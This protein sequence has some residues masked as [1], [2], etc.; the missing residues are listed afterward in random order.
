MTDL[1]YRGPPPEL[2]VPDRIPD[3]FVDIFIDGR[4]DFSSGRPFNVNTPHMGHSDTISVSVGQ[5]ILVFNSGVHFS[6]EW[7][8]YDTDQGG[9]IQSELVEYL[10]N[11][12][13]GRRSSPDDVRIPRVTATYGGVEQ[14]RNPGENLQIDSSRPPTVAAALLGLG[15]SCS[16]LDTESRGQQ[17]LFLWPLPPPG[18]INLTFLW[19]ALGFTGTVL[20]DGQDLRSALSPNEDP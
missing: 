10:S 17:E 5:P 9:N 4:R 16:K 3:P 18:P 20:F 7:T 2:P 12:G 13:W 14:A 8:L 15:S 6:I 19:P 11:E 1:P